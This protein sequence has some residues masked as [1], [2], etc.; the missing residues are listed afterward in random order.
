MKAKET[1][2]QH[3]FILKYIW[4][5]NILNQFKN[6]P[7]NE[8]TV[9]EHALVRKSCY[10]IQKLRSLNP[11]LRFFVDENL[12]ETNIMKQ[13]LT[14]VESPSPPPETEKNQ[15]TETVHGKQYDFL[16]SYFAHKTFLKS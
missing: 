13:I 9:H 15:K 6:K 1:K 4:L 11:D 14:N 16:D 2:D 12:M 7:K 10:Q 3:H 8:R 5:K